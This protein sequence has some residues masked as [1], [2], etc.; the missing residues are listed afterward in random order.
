M[1]NYLGPYVIIK[2]DEYIESDFYGLTDGRMFD[3]QIF[4]KDRANILLPNIEIEGI[5]R[6][7][8]VNGDDQEIIPLDSKLIN[9]EKKLFK[10]Q[11]KDDIKRIIKFIGKNG[12]VYVEFGFVTWYS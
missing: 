10:N 8:Y 1:S 9:A 7:V 12:I 3:P 4:K 2:S 6:T 5:N 11:F